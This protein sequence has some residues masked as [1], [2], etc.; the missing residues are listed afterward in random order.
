MRFKFPVQKKEL[1][2]GEIKKQKSYIDFEIDV[3]LASQIRYETKFPELAKNEDLYGYSARICAIKELSVAK[4]LSE[5]KLLY[6]WIDTD[7]EF[8]EFL[9]LFDL[10]DEE[11]VKELVK[12][13]TEAFDKIFSSSAEKN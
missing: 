1:L 12:T 3:T 10:T 8:I 5:L 4:I 11:Y 6:C 13:L 7:L 2:N 9:K